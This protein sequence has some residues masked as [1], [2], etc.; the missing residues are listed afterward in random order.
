M[1]YCK[2]ILPGRTQPTRRNY[3]RVETAFSGYFPWL[4]D[5]WATVFRFSLKNWDRATTYIPK[6]FYRF[7]LLAANFLLR[8]VSAL[9]ISKCRLFKNQSSANSSVGKAATGD[10]SCFIKHICIN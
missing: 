9:S 4:P 8:C 1:N 2:K 6:V 7:I 5:R 10:T 3:F